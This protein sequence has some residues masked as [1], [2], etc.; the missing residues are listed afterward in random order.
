MA[1]ETTPPEPQWGTENA[2]LFDAF[3]KANPEDAEALRQQ[4]CPLCRHMADE[5]TPPGIRGITCERR[6]CGLRN[7]ERL[8]EE[9]IWAAVMVHRL[10][11]PANVA[12]ED[13]HLLNEHIAGAGCVTPGFLIEASG[14]LRLGWATPTLRGQLHAAIVGWIAGLAGDVVRSPLDQGADEAKALLARQ[15]V[16]HTEWRKKRAAALRAAGRSDKK[17]GQLLGV[18]PKMIRNWLGPRQAG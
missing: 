8:Q 17:I 6:R 10:S 2:R 1:T 12:P 11:D 9:Q 16:H 15:R 13:V 7:A 3:I 18:D 4:Y 5:N 14:Q